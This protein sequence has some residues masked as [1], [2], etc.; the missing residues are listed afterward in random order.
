M[1][2]VTAT[3]FVTTH[4]IEMLREPSNGLTAVAVGRKEGG[5]LV[6][7][8]DFSIVGFVPRKLKANALTK[9]NLRPFDKVYSATPGAPVPSPTD[10]DVIE[11]G[12]AFEPLIEFTVPTPLRGQY[13]GIPPLLN[14][15][16]W[17]ASLRVGI[18]VTNPANAYPAS[19][20]AGTAGF[21]M[22]D[23]DGNTYLVS[24]NH[25]IGRS[26]NAATGETV[27]QPGTLD[28]TGGELAAMPTLADLEAQ[29]GV[30]EFI[31]SVP[32]QFMTSS[33]I[34]INEVDA[35]M[36][37]LTQPGR[38]LRDL[39]RL[40]YGGSI[41]GVAAPYQLDASGALQGSSRVYKVG[42]TTGYTEG[43][44]TQIAAVTTI[45]YDGGTAYFTNQIAIQATADN[46]GLFSDRGDSGSGVLNDRHELMGLLFAGSAN[47]TLIN[48]IAEVIDALRSSSGIQSLDVI[49]G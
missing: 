24:N 9:R 45:P 19:L 16:K 32:I 23:D 31:S 5:P 36:A 7:A 12:T 8:T 44:V 29:L 18:G 42:R 41:L 46:V 3:E 28:L 22:Q 10:L 33:S 27:V 25:V 38:D 11:S 1:N 13:G 20:S 26:N 39:D 49:V 15:Q 47:R 17:F 21:Y 40:S 48:P 6:G 14:A 30:A 35:A 43:V 4:G 2:L 37:R 34:P